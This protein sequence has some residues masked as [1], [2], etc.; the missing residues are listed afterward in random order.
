MSRW[1]K[2]G[3]HTQWIGAGNS[4]STLFQVDDNPRRWQDVGNFLESMP[5]DRDPTDEGIPYPVT[6]W[7]DIEI[8]AY[9]IFFDA[10]TAPPAAQSVSYNGPQYAWSGQDDPAAQ[11]GFGP[12]NAVRTSPLRFRL[13]YQNE[14]QRNRFVDVDVGAGIKLA[15]NSNQVVVEGLVPVGSIAVNEGGP[16][17]TFTPGPGETWGQSLVCGTISKQDA[18][19]GDRWA[20]LTEPLLAAPGAS[21]TLLETVKIPM[22]AKKITIVQTD[23]G[24]PG[25]FNYFS[26]ADS[27]GPLGPAVG[28]IATDPVTRSSR[29]TEI[30]GNASYITLASPFPGGLRRFNLVFELEF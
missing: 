5:L 21:G 27:T 29:R 8:W 30:P 4:F 10:G 26:A 23:P 22:A 9:T 1:L 11:P 14:S 2:T 18:P 12:A 17:Q 19:I 24:P 7:W 16:E 20:T 3:Y 28:S 6:V 13:R 15:V 25:V